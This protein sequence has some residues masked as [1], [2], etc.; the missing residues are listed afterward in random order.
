MTANTSVVKPGL[1]VAIAATVIVT[2]GAAG[3]SKNTSGSGTSSTTG[4]ASSTAAPKATSTA[5]PSPGNSSSPSGSAV[6]SATASARFVGH[7]Q[8]HGAT[9][10][11]TP[12]TATIVAGLGMGPCSENPQA[13]CSETDTLAVVSG[14]DTQLALTVTAVSYALHNGQTTS[15]N[16]N[17]G[18]S[19]AEGDSVQLVWQA[20]GLLKQTVGQGGNPY[21]C[22][23]GISESNRTLCGA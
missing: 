17:P 15:V 4:T 21:W 16:P 7:W 9:L 23:A 22:G 20:P 6:P 3:C 1:A 2:V 18:P 5:S 13:A 12:A 10:D 8:V 14:N 11:I 19:A